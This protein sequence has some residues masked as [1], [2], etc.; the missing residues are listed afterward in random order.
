MQYREPASAACMASKNIWSPAPSC[1]E[2]IWRNDGAL[3]RSLIVEKMRCTD[4]KPTQ[5][6]FDIVKGEGLVVLPRPDY[7]SQKISSHG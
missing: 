5:L 7:R 6:E 1:L 3:G 2:M 4:V